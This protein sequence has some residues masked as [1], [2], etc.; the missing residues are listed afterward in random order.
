MSNSLSPSTT[1]MVQVSKAELD[2]LLE[3]LKA[4]RRQRDE[5]RQDIQRL[6]E[7]V[8]AVIK[9]LGIKSDKKPHATQLMILV[10]KIIQNLPQYE[11]LFNRDIK[12]LLQK[13]AVE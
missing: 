7:A 10:P 12:P 11:E 1:N 9:D 8:G 13:Y 2:L 4:H 5:L 6:K 3:E